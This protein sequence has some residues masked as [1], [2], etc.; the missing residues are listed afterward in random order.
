LEYLFEQGR[1]SNSGGEVV[2]DHRVD[3][4]AMFQKSRLNSLRKRGGTPKLGPDSR[5]CLLSVLLVGS[6]HR[7]KAFLSAP[8]SQRC[9]LA[10]YLVKQPSATAAYTP[11][12]LFFHDDHDEKVDMHDE[13]YYDGEYDFDFF[14]EGRANPRKESK[15]AKGEGLDQVNAELSRWFEDRDRT[16]PILLSDLLGLDHDDDENEDLSA[17][18]EEPLIPVDDFKWFEPFLREIEFKY[19]KRREQLMLSLDLDR[20]ATPTTV[21][22]NA[23]EALEDVLQEEMEKEIRETLD[24]M[25]IQ[26]IQ[27]KQR[28]RELAAFKKK[29]DVKEIIKQAQNELK[30]A[31]VISA[32]R[33]AQ[34]DPFSKKA[35]KRALYVA[36]QVPLPGENGEASDLDYWAIDRLEDVL[37]R[38]QSEGSDRRRLI[39]Q[40]IAG[41]RERLEKRKADRSFKP[42][43]YADWKK[44]QEI[45]AF[46]KSKSADGIVDEQE[47]RRKFLDWKEFMVRQE[48]TMNAFQEEEKQIEK[49]LLT[50]RQYLPEQ[51]RDFNDV[52]ADINRKALKA[53]EEVLEKRRGSPGTEEL[54][55]RISKLR[56]SLEAVNFVDVKPRNQKKETKVFNDEP[57]DFSDVFPRQAAVLKRGMENEEMVR[58]DKMN[59]VLSPKRTKERALASRSPVSASS[60]NDGSNYDFVSNNPISSIDPK[61]EEPLSPPPPPDTPFFASEMDKKDDFIKDDAYVMSES[62]INKPPEQRSTSLLG[63]YEEQRLKNIFRQGGARTTEEQNKVKQE[64]EDFQRYQD[65]M[66]KRLEE[67]DDSEIDLG[68]DISDVLTEDGDIDAAKVLSYLKTSSTVRSSSSPEASGEQANFSRNESL[69]SRSDAGDEDESNS[70]NGG[71]S[72]SSSVSSSEANIKDAQDSVRSHPVGPTVYKFSGKT[73]I[74][75]GPDERDTSL[76]GTYEDQRLRSMYREMGLKTEEDQEKFRQEYEAFQRYQEDQL[77]QFEDE[78]GEIDA[79]KLSSS[80]DE[81]RSSLSSVDVMGKSRRTQEH[82]KPGSGPPRAEE[83]GDVELGPKPSIAE[84]KRRLSRSGNRPDPEDL[85][86]DPD[87]SRGSFLGQDETA[88]LSSIDRQEHFEANQRRIEDAFGMRRSRGG[89]DISEAFWRRRG[90]TSADNEYRHDDYA[91]PV[92]KNDLDLSSYQ[93]RKAML[94][95][96]KALSV[97]EVNALM[98]MKDSLESEGLSP[99]MSRIN[100]P[101]RE[102][103]AIFRMEGVLVDTSF[104]EHRAWKR[105]AETINMKP[106]T[107]EEARLA[108]VQTPEYAIGRIFYWTNDYQQCQDIAALHAWHLKEEV[109]KHLVDSKAEPGGRNGLIGFLGGNSVSEPSRESE[110]EPK[111]LSTPHEIF[112]SMDYQSQRNELTKRMYAAFAEKYGFR[113]PAESE[114]EIAVQLP[115]REAV[116]DVFDWARERSQVDNIVTALKRIYE[117]ERRRQLGSKIDSEALKDDEEE[118]SAVDSKSG[119]VLIDGAKSWIKALLDVEMPCGLVSYL[120]EESVNLILDAVGLGRL[121]PADRRVTTSSGYNRDTFQ[122]LGACIRIDRR[123]DMVVMFDGNAESLQAAREND[124]KS[125]GVTS[126]YPSYELLAADTTARNFECLTAMNIRRLFGERENQEPML[127]EYIQEP[128]RPKK[129]LMTIYPDDDTDDTSGHENDNYSEFTYDNY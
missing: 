46:E 53:L 2:I 20:K 74:N 35:R 36:A 11:N 78:E 9:S 96:R 14:D 47:V 91:I 121:I 119:I 116:E 122:Q 126:I 56:E 58:E 39:E 123:P 31:S 1:A 65:E 64:Y 76:L 55:A 129:K 94:L 83:N 89:I 105:V 62:D 44:Y 57:I 33:E 67:M 50:V 75:A 23:N 40:K 128:S 66:L 29:E 85:M 25:R 60:F 70:P 93:S 82:W 101:F 117:S 80:I 108:S 22:L 6:I 84:R 26:R 111:E 19:G 102:F 61:E 41:M 24:E 7:N 16:Q 112:D 77:K 18:K 109:R 27:R 114:L 12:K 45:K 104:L 127:Q 103:G 106:P 63:S 48:L 37:L 17:R 30:G 42:D 100:K 34:M 15:K 5:T 124:M 4:L 79:E 28:K 86:D 90:E 98:D 107:Q 71:Q 38:G 10:T 110:S 21:P 99:Y 54:E 13:Q 92:R 59:Q 49:E 88:S 69:T 115:P 113:K 95:G 52:V 81:K 73:D 125:V 120:D 3:T 87:S 51:K 8:L 32:G 43:T 68:Y 72:W 97:M 118:E